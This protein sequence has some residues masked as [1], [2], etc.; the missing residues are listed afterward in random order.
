MRVF[1][2]LVIMVVMVNSL[3]ME[4]MIAEEGKDKSSSQEPFYG[5]GWE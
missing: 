3:G 2:L 5:A 4:I 1:A